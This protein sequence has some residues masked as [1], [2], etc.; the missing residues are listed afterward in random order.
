MSSSA[1]AVYSMEALLAQEK[2]IHKATLKSELYV[3][4]AT[5]QLEFLV[6]CRYL[7][8]CVCRSHTYLVQFIQLFKR[9]SFAANIKALRIT[10]ELV[11]M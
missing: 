2:L 3:D 10:F 11:G 8:R 9:N 7:E 4:Y 1:P 5:R 6:T